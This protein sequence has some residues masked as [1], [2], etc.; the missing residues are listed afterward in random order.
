MY[1][2]KY[3]CTYNWCK[4]FK[5]SD[6]LYR[7]DILNIFGITDFDFEKHECEIFDEMKKIFDEISKNDQ[8]MECVNNACSPHFSKDSFMG[9]TMLFSYDFLHLTH[10]CIC[11]FLETGKITD[12]KLKLLQEKC[13][14]I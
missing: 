13:I 9:F 5:L 10:P 12:D 6:T 1:D 3:T 4:D 2:T 14:I 7:R 11:E 8:F